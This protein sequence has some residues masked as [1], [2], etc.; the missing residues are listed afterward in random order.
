MTT[1]KRD[2][3]GSHWIVHCRSEKHLQSLS[4]RFRRR[5]HHVEKVHRQCGL[6]HFEQASDTKLALEWIEERCYNC[7][8]SGIK[9]A[10]DGKPGCKG[11]ALEAAH[12]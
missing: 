5:R 12:A 8:Q 10:C 1:N 9:L 4:A 7:V 3:H 11:W 2:S 6:K